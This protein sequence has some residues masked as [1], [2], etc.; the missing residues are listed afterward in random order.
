M[1]RSEIE[2]LL[3][4]SLDRDADPVKVHG[5]MKALL[6]DYDFKSDFKDIVLKALFSGVQNVKRIEFLK[7]I[8]WAFSRVAIIS[9]AAIVL[10]LISIFINEGSFSLN[11]IFG[12]SENYDDTILSM[13]TGY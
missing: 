12:I 5:E 10:L 4:A 3:L 11:A 6:P 2:K 9:V 7:S 1:D 13:L 8:S